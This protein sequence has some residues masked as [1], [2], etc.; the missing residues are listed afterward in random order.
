[1]GSHNIIATYQGDAANNT[2]VS[3][4]LAQNVLPATTVVLSSSRNPA[5]AGASITY[6]ASVSGQGP[7]PT[8]SVTFSDGVTQLGISSL[9]SQGVATLTLSTLNVGSHSIIASYAGDSSNA[10]STSTS[11]GQVI[12][13]ATTQTSL[14]ANSLTITRGASLSLTASITG[15]GATATGTVNF[16]DGSQS[17]GTS[18]LNSSGVATLTAPGLTVGQ[19]SLTAVY[20]GDTNDLV[21]NSS[22]LTVTVVQALPSV[23]ITSSLSPSLTGTAVTF[24]AAL[25]NGVATPSGTITW[26]DG[27]TCLGSS[28]LIASGTSSFTA[29]ALAV[30]THTIT[31]VYSGDTNNA[32]ATSPALTQTVQQ[33]TTSAVQ[34][35]SN[36]T[37]SGTNVHFIASVVGNSG[38][39]PTGAVTFKDGAAVLAT[40]NLSN[41]AATFDTTSLATGVHSI[42]IVYSG[43]AGSQASTSAVWTQTVT[44]ATT[45]VAL[46]SSANPSIVGG[47]ITFTAVVTGNGQTA[48]GTVI[49]SD[50]A[51]V[52]GTATLVS[53]R[54]TYTTTALLSGVH[55]ITA[56]YSGDSS[57]QPATS[58][59]L[60]QIVQQ[61]TTTTLAT[62]AN[63]IQTAQALQLTAT[64]GNSGAAATGTVNFYDGS[65]V[66]GSSTLNAQ[67]TASFN[68]TALSAGQHSLTASY[69]G[70]QLNLSSASAAL[71]ETVQLRSSSTTLASSATTISAGQQ[72]TLFADVQSSS[73]LVATGVISFYSGPTLIGSAALGS[74]GVAIL[75]YSPA[76]GTYNITASYAGDSVYS[77]SVSQ[78]IGPVIVDP[79]TEFTLTSSSSSVQMPT[80]QYSVVTL[81]LQSAPGF[82]D[83]M[84]LGCLGLPSLAT[85]NFSSNLVSLSPNGTKTVQLTID[86]GSPQTA[87]GQARLRQASPLTLACA[88]PAGA[89]LALL[90]FTGRRNRRYF[91]G[92]LLLTL[93]AFTVGLS[94]CGALQTNGTP[95]GTYNI[96]VTAVGQ[97]TGVSQSANIVLTVTQ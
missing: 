53:G 83:V 66:L 6:T 18:S 1:M 12:Q 14:N 8:G 30:G 47:V 64:V 56:Q 59:P 33:S 75:N 7:V 58:A 52:L 20:S 97:K 43:D 90:I 94:G 55:A 27:V 39:M 42:T 21:S 37:I 71:T 72:I 38:N 49:F 16:M 79:T 61:N 76:Q 44:S 46:S 63:P 41:G 92:L 67:G 82:S 96:M 70:D 24:T 48:T 28:A 19:H 89:L 65:T 74:T 5:V 9:N 91:A 51:N 40:I 25:G 68:L 10:S 77:A 73:P 45:A 85:C 13:Q 26:Y 15:N 54:I 35:T 22:I 80:K 34:S 86:T 31:G 3:A 50:G 81:T 93:A 84:E 95:V 88:L 57:N 17:L 69:T 87:G 60:S 29:S 23:Q 36:Q 11:L 2:A 78:P 4:T 62:S 32:A